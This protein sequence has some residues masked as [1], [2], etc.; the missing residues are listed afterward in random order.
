MS[1]G[2]DFPTSA[3]IKDAIIGTVLRGID[4][5][6]P[7]CFEIVS[8]PANQGAARFVVKYTAEGSPARFFTVSVKEDK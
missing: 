6:L 1:K 7:H 2:K 8:W 5:H 3:S 4:S